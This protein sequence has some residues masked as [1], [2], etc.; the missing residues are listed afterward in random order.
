[1]P[2]SASVCP[3][4][5]LPPPTTTATCPPLR[6][7]SAIC[8]AMV[9][10]VVGSMPS[11]SPPAN[12]SPESLSSTRLQ[13]GASP[14]RSAGEGATVTGSSSGA[15]WGSERAAVG[16]S[17]VRSLPRAKGP[18][19]PTERPLL[20]DIRRRLVSGAA[21]LE[22]GEALDADASR[23]EHLLDRLLVVLDV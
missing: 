5:M 11:D 17:A 8:R 23:V 3:R 10:T 22:A 1:M 7:T 18:S 9:A 15:D 4:N 19:R 21:D 12:A 6:T 20:T 16:G 13:R 14:E 2:R